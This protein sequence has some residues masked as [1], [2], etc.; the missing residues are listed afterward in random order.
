VRPTILDAQFGV[1][2]G[3]YNKKKR[4]NLGEWSGGGGIRFAMGM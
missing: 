2:L 3:M 4:M 1:Q